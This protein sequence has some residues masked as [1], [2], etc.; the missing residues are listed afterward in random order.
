MAQFTDPEREWRIGAAVMTLYLQHVE[1]REVLRPHPPSVQGSV[2][3]VWARQ[4]WPEAEILILKIHNR[5]RFGS[6]ETASVQPKPF[7]LNR[8]S[9]GR[10]DINFG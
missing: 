9:F 5:E 10:T 8:H 7:R 1:I 6:T 2:G 3:L 4:R